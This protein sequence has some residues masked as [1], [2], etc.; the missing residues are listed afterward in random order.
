M[1]A[2]GTYKH[3]QISEFQHIVWD[4]YKTHK[5]PMPW[6][7]TDDPY[8]IYV[9][10]IMLQQTQVSRV[11]QKFTD[12]IAFYPTVASLAHAETHEL[13]SIWQGMGYNRR[14]LSMRQSAQIIVEKHKGIMPRE[15]SD[16]IALP[17]IGPYTASAIRAFAFDEPDI[18]IETNIRTVFIYH[19]FP[20]GEDISDKDIFPFIE[21]S[22]DRNDPRGWY[23]ALMDYG[24]FLKIQ[25]ENPSK[26]SRHYT[27]QSTFQGS[28][29]QL[30]GQIIKMLL[31]SPQSE[32]KI[33]ALTESDSK[34]IK[35]ILLS[36]KKEGFIRRNAKKYQIA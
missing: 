7:D 22:I 6:R 9:S 1:P 26:K 15:K 28:D 21:T 8:L 19:F 34:R 33:I 23:Y 24:A 2:L 30:R 14:A 18:F 12:F 35:N 11:L 32:S 3:K 13:L 36:L 27:K 10:E 29:R 16:L 17:G 5:R 4:Y 25:E 31:T 20:D